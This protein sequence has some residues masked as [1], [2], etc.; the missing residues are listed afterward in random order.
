MR[1]AS[2]FSKPLDRHAFTIKYEGQA[3]LTAEAMFAQKRGRVEAGSVQADA[4]IRG[5]NRMN[6]KRLFSSIAAGTL[7]S[8]ALVVG[9]SAQTGTTDAQTKDTSKSDGFGLE[10]ITVMARRANENLQ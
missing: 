3:G 9:A 2:I 8:W 6:G 1:I 10:E 7:F 5:G 4:G